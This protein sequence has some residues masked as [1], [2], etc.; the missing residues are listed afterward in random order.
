M[1]LKKGDR[2]VV[3]SGKDRGKEGVIMRVLPKENKV[4]VEGVNIVK[5]HQKQTRQT[6]QAG[7][8]D[9]DMPIHASNV[10]L[11]SHGKP[12]RIGNRFEPDGTKV[13]IARRTGEV[14][15]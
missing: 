4:I 7:I 10:A 2:V 8:I 13:R 6:M 5:K 3:L 12:S 14:L 15:P 1:K 11:V 9:K